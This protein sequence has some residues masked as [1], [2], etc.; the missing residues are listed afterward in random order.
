LRVLDVI[1]RL[2]VYRLSVPADQQTAII[3]DLLGTSGVE[4]AEPNYLLTIR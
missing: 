1:E 4:Y 2:N 3:N